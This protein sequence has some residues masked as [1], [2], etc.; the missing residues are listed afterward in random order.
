[1]GD[2]SIVVVKAV[3][4]GGLWEY[5]NVTLVDSSYKTP[6]VLQMEWPGGGLGMG[7]GTPGLFRS[8]FSW[9]QWQPDN[10]AMDPLLHVLISPA[11]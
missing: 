1:M 3:G 5:R 2:K 8:N 4:R 11:V 7:R 6:L 10:L 9:Q